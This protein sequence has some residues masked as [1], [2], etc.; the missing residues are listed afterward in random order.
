VAGLLPHGLIKCG[1]RFHLTSA[2]IKIL[3]MYLS[4]EIE[5]LDPVAIGKRGRADK[6]W[7]ALWFD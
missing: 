1:T 6:G 7:S 4:E 5:K 3:Y 2:G